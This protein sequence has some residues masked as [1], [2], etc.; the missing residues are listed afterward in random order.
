MHDKVFPRGLVRFAL[1]AAALLLSV[2]VGWAKI[3]DPAG[4]GPDAMLLRSWAESLDPVGIDVVLGRATALPVPDRPRLASLKGYV[5]VQHDWGGFVKEAWSLG[6]ERGLTGVIFAV[7]P[8]DVPGNLARKK[9]DCDSGAAIEIEPCK[10]VN[11]W[12][13]AEPETRVFI[14]FTRDDIDA[15]LAVKKSLEERGFVVFVFLK[16]RSATP[17]ADPALVGE[18]FAQAAHRLVIDSASARESEGV[19][20]ESLCCEPLLL[21]PYPP[22]RWSEALTR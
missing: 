17:W 3:I 10:F 8:S 1:G 19:K 7:R 12:L 22:S 21:P 9:L 18:V 6:F 2:Y 13:D 11:D 4:D 14:A 5:P 16:G 15:A 20:F